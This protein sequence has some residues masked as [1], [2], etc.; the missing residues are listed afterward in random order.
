MGDDLSAER[1]SA[2][3]GWLTSWRSRS[4]VTPPRP[5]AENDTKVAD[6]IRDLAHGLL[7]L[8]VNTIVKE[9]MV[10]GPMPTI[11]NALIEIASSYIRALSDDLLFDVSDVY[12]VPREAADDKWAAAQVRRGKD[13]AAPFRLPDNLEKTISFAHL[14]LFLRWAARNAAQIATDKDWRWAN[15]NPDR[16]PKEQDCG[17][18][19]LLLLR[20]IEDNSDKIC[21]V[22][23]ADKARM[24][25]TPLQPGEQRIHFADQKVS[26]SDIKYRT[27]IF[28]PPP[29]LTAR[30]QLT[31]KKIWE[32]GSE[33]V[34][35]QTVIQLDGDVVTRIAKGFSEE[36]EIDKLLALH[37][38][39]L[40]TGLARWDS[41]ANAAVAVVRG[42]TGSIL[43]AR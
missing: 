9:N 37:Q 19:E 30:E 13:G 29:D 34:V 21:A 1:K 40:E 5:V 27:D 24:D 12:K 33:W 17:R 14:F 31:I 35:A 18:K 20:R 4:T 2:P 26:L 22:L 42:L 38:R 25:S 28:V 41:L 43:G 8:E 3:F 11:P 15:W 36:P 39:G 6:Q 16:V 23:A 10:A 7:T 32:V